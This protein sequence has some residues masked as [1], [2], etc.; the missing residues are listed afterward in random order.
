MQHAQSIADLVRLENIFD[1][2]D[3]YS[4]LSYRFVDM[5]P[6]RQQIKSAQSRIDHLIQQGVAEI[7]KLIDGGSTMSVVSDQG[8]FAN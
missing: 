1:V 2:M 6:H 5:Y 7:T 8:K 4:W 3:L